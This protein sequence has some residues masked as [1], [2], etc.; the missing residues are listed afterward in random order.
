MRSCEILSIEKIEMR[1]FRGCFV[2]REYKSSRTELNCY[3]WS[4]NCRMAD[5]ENESNQT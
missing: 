4:S 3:D 5:L 1:N 2:I